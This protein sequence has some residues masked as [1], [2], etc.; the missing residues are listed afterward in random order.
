MRL[1]SSSK[2][3]PTDDDNS[4]MDQVLARS[5][6]TENTNSISIILL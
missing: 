2:T 1:R 3:F 4:E 5:L 6:P